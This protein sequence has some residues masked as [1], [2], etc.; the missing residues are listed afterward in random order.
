[1]NLYTKNLENRSIF[2][3]VMADYILENVMQQ[4]CLFFFWS[5]VHEIAILAQCAPHQRIGH[6]ILISLKKKISQ[7]EPFLGELWTFKFSEKWMQQNFHFIPLCPH[8]GMT[9]L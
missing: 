8:S 2:D 5:A 3:E 9:M 1:M 4:S 6:K 7:I